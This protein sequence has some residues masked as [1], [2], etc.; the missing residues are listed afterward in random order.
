MRL[1]FFILFFP[2]IIFAQNN[3]TL[4][5]LLPPQQTGVT[6]EN[7][8]TDEKE[9]NILLYSNYYGGAGVGIGDFNNDGLQDVFFAGNLVGDKLYL[10][11]GDFEFKDHTELAGIENNGGWS[12]GVLVADVNNDG[13]QD[14]YVTRELYDDKPELRRNVLYIN[15]GTS[16]AQRG[17]WNV[18]FTE[19]AAEYGIDDAE[20]TRHAT[21]IDYNKDGHLDLFL[22][23]QPPNPGNYS[24]FYGTELMTNEWA[25]RLYKNNGNNTFS[26]VTKAAGVLKPGYGNSVIAADINNDGWQD[27]YVANDYEA[28]DFLYLNQGDGTFK[29]II[30]KS[31]RHISYYAMGVD[32]ADINND[33][34]LD[35]MTLDMVAEDNF[36]LKSNM[37]GMY[38]EAFWKIVKEGGHHQYMFNALHLNSGDWEISEGSFS[39]I[40]QLAGVSS[41]DWSWAN[42][43]A[44]FDNDGWKDI[45]VTNGL[46]RDIRNTDSSKE[47]PKYVRKVVDEFI[48]NNPNAGDVDIFDILD[49]NEALD[50]IPSVPLKN[51]AFKNNGDLT[52]SKMMDAWGFDKETFS[53][54][55]A[56][57]DL[58]NDGDLDLV[59]NNINEVAHIYENHSEKLDNNWLRIKL[60]DSKNHTSLLGSKIEIDAEGKKQF[61]ELANV[62][63]MYSTSENMAHFGVGDA[64][65]VS[66]LVTFPDG[67]EAAFSSIQTNQ[68][69]T[70]DLHGNHIGLPRTA[71]QKPL[72]NDITT[73]TNLNFEH[74]EN[75]FDDYEKQVLLPHKMSQFGP[76]VAV[77]DV[78]GDGLEDVFCGGAKGFSAQL[79]IQSPQGDFVNLP[80]PIFETD[81]EYEDVDAVFFDVDNDGDLDLYVVSGGNAHP[82]QN[83]M[84][85][86]RLYLNEG[87]NFK[88]S[89]GV[90]P[91]FRESGSCVRPHDFD[92]D[93]D[94][95][96][97]IGGRHNPWDY[98]APT[99]SR[100]LRNDGGKFTDITKT[101]AKDLIFLGLVTDAVWSDFDQD[102]DTDLIIVGEWMPI[103]FFENKEGGFEKI[104]TYKS[105]LGSQ[106]GWWYSIEKADIDEDGD[107]DYFVG[108]LGLNYKYKASD[109]EPFEVHYD[110]FDQSGK[111]DIVLSYY[112]FGEQYPLRGRSCSSEQVPLLKEKFPTY[113]I[114]ASADLETVYGGDN[115]ANA[116]HYSANSFASV[117]IENQG[118]GNFKMTPLPN[119]AQVSSI[120]D[121]E[122]NDF[123]GDGQKDIFLAGNLYT[124]EIETTRNDAGIG[125]ILKGDGKGNWQPLK[126]SESGIS[127]PYDVKKIKKIR[128]EKGVLYLIGVNDG[129]MRVLSSFNK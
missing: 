90:L 97:F 49:L 107:D 24:S 82:P 91:R 93:G 68:I 94:L 99:V 63:G 23:N 55:V 54:G 26:D 30:Q 36:R 4:F 46:L 102:N 111:K 37:G 3:Q 115:L 69:F 118:N 123:D 52:F 108:N 28:P 38:P 126:P 5:Q 6:F 116:L 67:K 80:R 57:A 103:T 41:T 64:Q 34:W 51:Y 71:P 81:K 125:L 13:W 43:I 113:N 31:A 62:R 86:D 11:Q 110:D 21:F 45:Y 119:E 79:F 129:R 72:F 39:D 100:L 128:T 109:S 9:H 95:D 15:N 83:K 25:P 104:D 74:Q 124:S 127:L 117:Y 40:A 12:S 98:P 73:N 112:N 76:A 2:F 84:Y 35:L 10:N 105:A 70:I 7:T 89:E 96:L 48:K 120:N 8:I 56:Y 59:V 78:N 75:E 44:D 42:V 20:R 22:L 1:L 29:D 27:L 122:I 87:G 53:N 47:F 101:N 14:I 60:T 16:T 106:V 18:T 88:K 121:F 114:F 77:G 33:G 19:K 61:F 17:I 85:E 65:F 32:A 58:D 92:N 66:I 50:L